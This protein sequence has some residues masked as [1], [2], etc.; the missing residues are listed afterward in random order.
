MDDKKIGSIERYGNIFQTVIEISVALCFVILMLFD[1]FPTKDWFSKEARIP[2]YL[3][4]DFSIGLFFV[5]II[6]RFFLWQKTLG[7]QLCIGS[8][9]VPPKIRFAKLKFYFDKLL[10]K[11]NC[12]Y[13]TITD[14]MTFVLVIFGLLNEGIEFYGFRIVSIILLTFCKCGKQDFV[15]FT[16]FVAL[17]KKDT[18][19]DTD[20]DQSDDR[21]KFLRYLVYFNLG[22]FVFL[23]FESIRQPNNLVGIWFVTTFV[24]SFSSLFYIA[25]II[26]RYDEIRK[27]NRDKGFL[28][29]WQKFLTDDK[30]NVI[31]MLLTMT[32]L[33]S[34]VDILVNL[35]VTFLDSYDIHKVVTEFIFMKEGGNEYSRFAMI[36]RPFAQLRIFRTEKKLKEITRIIAASFRGILWALFYF[37]VLFVIYGAVGHMIL[38]QTYGGH[39]KTFPDA[40][41]SLFRIMTFES[42]GGLMEE[43][44]RYQ[45]VPDWI[46]IGYYYS[47]IIF[48]SYIMW[49]V[50]QG[51]IVS[52]IQEKEQE[53][54]REDKSENKDLSDANLAKKLDTFS[55]DVRKLTKEIEVMKA[56]MKKR[57]S[58]YDK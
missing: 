53:I 38:G 36:I 6:M 10:C 37:V 20:K 54:E 45:Q 22:C 34:I 11:Y 17:F 12:D 18:K 35:I 32:A 7:R 1:F 27:K 24:A 43:T 42:W 13:T 16:L 30:W 8:N 4:V 50:I 51:L 49:S 40:I 2:I 33:I 14:F 3:I 52:R 9:T 21:N 23:T 46:V 56:I 31:D 39:F 26:L 57:R 48:V 47:F 44:M 55:E 15:N 5:E 41:Q 58:E 25:D 29:V 19:D 28:Y